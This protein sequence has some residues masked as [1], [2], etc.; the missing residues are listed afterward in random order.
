MAGVARTAVGRA[1]IVAVAARP[2]LGGGRRAAGAH[3][4][5]ARATALRRPPPPTGC[6]NCPE[7]D[8]ERS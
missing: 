5:A 2:R 7:T 8:K 3:A 4:E 6:S 1:G